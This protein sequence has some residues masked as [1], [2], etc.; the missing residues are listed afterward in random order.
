M[1]RTEDSMK[2]LE[3]ARRRYEKFKELFREF[4]RNLDLLRGDRFPLRCVDVNHDD[5]K[6]SN[7]NFLGRN[8]CIEFT[9]VCV[10]GALKGRIAFYRPIENQTSNQLKS[11]TFNGQGELDI[12]PAPGEDPLY[13]DKNSSCS[14]LVLEWIRSEIYS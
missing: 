7:L 2:E 1:N 6:R 9:M 11:A 14:S 4:Q 5:G 13:I 12:E 3:E 8:Y 10:D